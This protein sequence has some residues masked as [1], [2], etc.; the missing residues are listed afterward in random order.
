MWMMRTIKKVNEG[1]PSPSYMIFRRL[2]RYTT[3]N[4]AMVDTKS[5]SFPLSS[6]SGCTVKLHPIARP[7]FKQREKFSFTLD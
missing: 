6:V 7:E 1:L 5:S 2:L 4:W 3:M